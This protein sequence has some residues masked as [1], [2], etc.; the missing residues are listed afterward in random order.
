MRRKSNCQLCQWWYL[1]RHVQQWHS[2]RCWCVHVRHI[3]WVGGLKKPGSVVCMRVVHRDY[4]IQPSRLLVI[5]QYNGTSFLYWVVGQVPEGRRVH[6]PLWE[7]SEDWPRQSHVR[8]L[9]VVFFW[10]EKSNRKWPS[11]RYKKGGY[12]HGHFKDGQRNGEVEF[13]IPKIMAVEN[14][15]VKPRGQGTLQYANGDI[16]SGCILKGVICEMDTFPES[17]KVSNRH[18]Y[19]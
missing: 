19:L 3:L 9:T 8:G 4:Y 16:Y 11:S 18:L 13:Q 15:P 7:Q 2:A 1:R 12:F 17:P 5:N 10:V 6:R 14:V